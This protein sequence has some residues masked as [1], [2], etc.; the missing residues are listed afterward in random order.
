ML[1]TFQRRGGL[2]ITSS[3]ALHVHVLDFRARP[4]T[5]H[6]DP[7]QS[8]PSS[9]SKKAS[10]RAPSPFAYVAGQV[11]EKHTEK[12]SIESKGKTITRK[13]EPDN[14]AFKVERKGKNP[15][16]KKASTCPTPLLRYRD[17][18]PVGCTRR[19]TA[20]HTKGKCPCIG[21]AIVYS[22]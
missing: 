10:G 15:V 6:A 4:L 9:S 3:C 17:G 18:T 5:I 12:A 13:G 8:R 7:S 14:P 1:H 20:T 11:T 2:C 19:R 21:S 22:V 16:I